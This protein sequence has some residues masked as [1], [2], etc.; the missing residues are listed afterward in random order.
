MTSDHDD[1][2]Q[3]AKVAGA[4]CVRLKRE[5][6]DEQELRNRALVELY[7]QRRAYGLT[8]DQI[9]E[10]GSIKRSTLSGIVGST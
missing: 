2:R 10:L 4:N 7:E 3:R 9:A 1:P 5:L 6:E 8:C